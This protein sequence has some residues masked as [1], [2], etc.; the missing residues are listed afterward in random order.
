[1]IGDA[2]KNN[3]LSLLIIVL[4]FC[5]CGLSKSFEYEFLE[6]DG[7]KGTASI[8]KSI[9]NKA[10]I[11]G[12]VYDQNNT[13]AFLWSSNKGC[14][15]FRCPSF[16]ETKI[17]TINN[18]SIV[19]GYGLKRDGTTQS[20][21]WDFQRGFQYPDASKGKL[22]FQDLN[23]K[24]YAIGTV[25]VNGEITSY[26]WDVDKCNYNSFS[27]TVHAVSVN[28]H[29]EVAGSVFSDSQWRACYLAV[30]K[31]K[32]LLIIPDKNIWSRFEDINNQGQAVGWIENRSLVRA[33][34][35][36]LNK[37]I[38]Y[39]DVINDINTVRWG[40]KTKAY[41]INNAGQ[42]VGWSSK[43]TV[44]PLQFY[45]DGRAFYWSAENGIQELYHMI[46]DK[47]HWTD[48]I[49]AYD[50]NDMGMIVGWGITKN[51][52]DSRR[53]FCLKP[54]MKSKADLNGN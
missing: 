23:N 5:S 47:K 20:F 32:P 52:P 1:M 9:N 21:V 3:Y 42:I 40:G 10:E 49:K 53:A 48:L 45:D 50:I 39:L 54:L 26:F 35:W 19:L 24:N 17:I 13:V 30:N 22:H 11:V 14:T 36:E 28:D 41:A 12:E 38:I 46:D 6:I 25:T 43:G 2:I 51:Y 31:K 4:S 34:M 27:N 44:G 15:Y 8:A 29:L 18:N 33:F 16:I 37:G 7:L